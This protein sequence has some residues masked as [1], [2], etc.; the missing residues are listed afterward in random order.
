MSAVTA[1][2]Q[3]GLTLIELIVFIVVVSVGLAGILSVLNVTL[4]SSADPLIRKQALAVAE[5]MLDE[6]LSKSYQNDPGDPSNSSSTL[7]CTSATKVTCRANT[8]VDRQNYNDVDDYGGWNQAGVL[9]LTG[10]LVPGLGAYTVT[11]AVGAPAAFNGVAGKMVTV[12]VTGGAENVAL[13]GFRAN[14]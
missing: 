3:R 5:A 11:V 14:F 10:A 12:T 13:T 6:I 4:R 2:R 7:G 8:P 9:D 1:A